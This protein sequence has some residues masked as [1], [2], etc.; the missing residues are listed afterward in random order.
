MAVIQGAFPYDLDHILGGRARVLFA[1]TSVAVPDN[2][3]DIIN[4]ETPYAPQT[5]WTDFGATTEG[6]SYSRDM[7]SEGWEIEQATG[8][9]FEEITE[10]NRSL[11]VTLGE[12]KPETLQILENAPSITAIAAV[13]TTSGP[14]QAV[15][16]GGFTTVK[17]YRIAFI[18]QRNIASGIVTENATPKERGRFVAGILYNVG[19]SAEAAEV[20]FEKGAITGMPV[21]FASFPESGQPAGEEIGTWITEDAGTI[22]A[23]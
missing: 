14:Q 10:V 23:V 21:T 2:M 11:D 16:F 22:P 3:S 5:G 20:G 1:E 15:K 6:T 17:R 13:A 19:I 12:V 18:S 9:I 4:L 7:E 8:S